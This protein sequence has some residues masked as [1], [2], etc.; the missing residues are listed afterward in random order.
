MG[1]DQNLKNLNPQDS[2]AVLKKIA[3]FAGILWS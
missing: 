3:C 2:R 1:K